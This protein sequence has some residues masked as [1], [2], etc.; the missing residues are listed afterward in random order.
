MTDIF[1]NVFSIFNTLMI[2]IE[3]I[4]TIDNPMLFQIFIG[5]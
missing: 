5:S 1:E 4:F 2:P 3:W